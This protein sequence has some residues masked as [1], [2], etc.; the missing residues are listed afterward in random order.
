MKKAKMALCFE[1]DSVKIGEKVLQLKSSSS[2]H[3]RLPLSLRLGQEVRA[4]VMSALGNRDVKVTAMK[5]HKQFSHP[6]SSKLIRLIKSAGIKITQLEKAIIDV[7]NSC[8]VC[9]RFKKPVPRPIVS[10]PMATNFNEVIAMDLKVWGKCYFLVLIDLATRYCV[11]SVIKDKF[12]PTIIKGVFISW[13]S[14]LVYQGK[15]YL[16][17][18]VNLI[19]VRCK[20][21]AKPLTSAS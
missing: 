18:G 15:F 16:T 6:V 11:A 10:M 20:H 14:I 12:A 4:S 3:Y 21:S 17:M 19:T 9:V 8:D 7:T 1:T 13:I 5:L 2:G